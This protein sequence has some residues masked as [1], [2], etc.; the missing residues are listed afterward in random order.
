VISDTLS[1]SM[2]SKCL[3]AKIVGSNKNAE[4]GSQSGNLP[5]SAQNRLCVNG[6]LCEVSY[7]A[8]AALAAF[9][10]RKRFLNVFKTKIRP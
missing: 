10:F 9:I 2:K 1:V 8:K 5:N 6:P 7:F 3:K 4:S